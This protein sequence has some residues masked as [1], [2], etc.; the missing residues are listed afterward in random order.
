MTYVCSSP[1]THAHVTI[2]DMKMSYRLYMSMLLDQNI[3]INVKTNG[4]TKAYLFLKLHLLHMIW[5][6]IYY[7]FVRRFAQV[8]DLCVCVFYASLSRYTMIV[9]TSR[10]HGSCVYTMKT[11][12]FVFRT[13]LI[14]IRHWAVLSFGPPLNLCN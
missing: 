11:R 1:Y 14:F 8:C 7:W 6:S 4:G 12:S 10:D 2:I 13:A 3:K 9:D 5:L